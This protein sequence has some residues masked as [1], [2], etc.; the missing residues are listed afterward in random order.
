MFVQVG[1][2]GKSHAALFY[3]SM[4]DVWPEV[5][6]TSNIRTVEVRVC[7]RM[8]QQVKQAG[9][10]IIEEEGGGGGGGTHVLV[11]CLAVVV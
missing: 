7:V 10:A 9:H 8:R 4:Q 3:P 5:Y 1:A 6:I 2:N 11:P